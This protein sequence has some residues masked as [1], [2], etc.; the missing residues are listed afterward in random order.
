[1]VPER[2]W[3]RDSNMG[4]SCGAAENRAR[5]IARADA[6]ARPVDRACGA[7]LDAA[8]RHCG[9]DNRSHRHRSLPA[10]RRP[11]GRARVAARRGRRAAHWL[12]PA[13][14]RGRCCTA[15]STCM[16]WRAAGGAGPAFLRRAVAGRP[17]HGRA[18]HAVR[19]DRA[20]GRAGRGRVPAGRRV[21]A[22]ATQ[23]TATSAPTRW[24]GACSC[25]PGAP[26]SPTP[27]SPSPHCWR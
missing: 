1:M 27:R 26:C 4:E 24:T 8:M 16:A 12:L 2:R 20:H 25:T 18:D 17:R 7:R 9:D 22:G 21:A 19:R 11:A 3:V 14:R 6:R 15:P 5:S 13:R 23:L 10:R